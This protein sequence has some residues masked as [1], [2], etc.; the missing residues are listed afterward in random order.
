MLAAKFSR[1]QVCLLQRILG[2]SDVPAIT[3]QKS[4]VLGDVIFKLGMKITSSVNIEW[5]IW[6]GRP[7]TSLY[8][9]M[10]HN[11]RPVV[12]RVDSDVFSPN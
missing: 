8:Q 6:R 7:G 3:F 5:Y 2:T 12:L 10:P 9:R 1:R 4:V 11:P